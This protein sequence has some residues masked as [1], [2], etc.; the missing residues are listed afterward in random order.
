MD[1]KNNRL[2]NYLVGARKELKKVTWPTKQETT[3][4]SL[5]VI[6]ISVFVA[7]FLGGLDFLFSYLLAVVLR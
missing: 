5:V 2:V 1:L 7:A 3:K 6:G 4:Y